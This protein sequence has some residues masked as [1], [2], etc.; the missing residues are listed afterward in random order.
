MLAQSEYSCY[1]VTCWLQ[2]WHVALTQR[3][4]F[5]ASSIS[6]FTQIY[7]DKK[8]RVCF[9]ADD[10]ALFKHETI[11]QTPTY[12]SKSN[13]RTISS[14]KFQISFN[15][16]HYGNIWHWFLPDLKCLEI[17]LIILGRNHTYI[18]K[19]IYYSANSLF[20]YH[21]ILYDVLNQSYQWSME[22][23]KNIDIKT[24]QIICIYAITPSPAQRR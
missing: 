5:P 19:P 9:L 22:P 14:W 13:L 17:I 24:T 12:L 11:A 8:E 21:I 20:D 23:C 7:D 6:I 15:W 2:T 3:Y 10:Y 18:Y 16:K 1:H 4:N